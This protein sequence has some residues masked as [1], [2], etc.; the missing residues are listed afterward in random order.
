MQSKNNRF[1]AAKLIFIFCFLILGVTSVAF[2]QSSK[3]KAFSLDDSGI[4]WMVT[5]RFDAS[6]P[7][8]TSDVG[9]VLLDVSSGTT[10]KVTDYKFMLGDV[11]GKAD[12]IR[13]P[14]LKLDRDL[15]YN[16]VI[17]ILKKNEQTNKFETNSFITPEIAFD[18]LFSSSTQTKKIDPTQAADDSDT[19]SKNI[20]RTKQAS[21]KAK[22]DSDVY[23]AGEWGGSRGKKT[24][25]STEIKIAPS[26]TNKRWIYTPFF[27]NLNASTSPA[28][29]PDNLEIGANATYVYPF[30]LSETEKWKFRLTG[31]N[32]TFG[33]KLESEKDF[34]NTNLLFDSRM[35]FVLTTV[36]LGKKS[37]L[38][39]D[40]FIGTE[41]GKNLKSPL[42]AA[43]GDGIARVFSG[44]NIVLEVP[45]GKTGLQGIVWENSYIRR[46]LFTDELGYE[47]DDN[48]ELILTRFGKSP[49]DYF[50]SKVEFTINR[51]LNP[52]VSY[53]WGEL[54]PSYKLVD[55]RFRVGFVYKF[56][57]VPR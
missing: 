1:K 17:S 8:A 45:L 40:P 52:Y 23:V 35:H 32:T 26:F 56:R 10:L 38:S 42:P 48:D 4:N 7:A 9:V 46:W 15:T 30:N 27:F 33:G 50:Q 51:F 14:L 31:L 41:L 43:Q 47:T 37:T 18:K 19:E 39:I 2:S 5:L 49:R 24:A 16:L 11:A 53:E 28:A 25:F 55:H 22:K 57:L 3:P 34:D 36:P 29:D 20:F 12:G 44:A 13:I 21:S 54:P 6:V